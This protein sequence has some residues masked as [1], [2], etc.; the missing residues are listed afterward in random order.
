ME[1]RLQELVKAVR[2]EAGEFVESIIGQGK[3]GRLVRVPL[4][5]LCEWNA[6]A[7]ARGYRA[8]YSDGRGA[9]E[10]KRI[11]DEANELSE[12]D[13]TKTVRGIRPVTTGQHGDKK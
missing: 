2:R 1:E 11:S 4:E 5:A 7:Y 6:G 9:A 3:L 8:G 10:L 13:R 12:A